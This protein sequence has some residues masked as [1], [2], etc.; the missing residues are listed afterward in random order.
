[1]WLML[2]QKEADDYI[3]ASGNTYTLKSFIE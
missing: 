1:M 3:I 2:Q